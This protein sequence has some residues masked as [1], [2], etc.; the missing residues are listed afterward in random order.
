[1]QT[2]YIGAG[3]VGSCS[4]AVMA[5]FGHN[6]V[7]Y[8]V[9][10]ERIGVFNTFNRDLIEASFFEQ[11]LSSLIIQNKQRMVFLDDYSQFSNYFDSADV[12]FICVPTPLKDDDVGDYDLSYFEAALSELS[13]ALTKRNGGAQEK[14][15]VV[16]VKSTVP[17]E[18]QERVARDFEKAGVKNF[19]VV[20]NPE[21]LVEGQAIKD[22][23]S[24][25]R[26]VVGASQEKDFSVMRELYQRF[27]N[28]PGV[29]YIEVNPREAAAGKLLSNYVLLS[30]LVTT[31]NVIGRTSEVIPGIQF[32]KLR[33][34]ITT[35]K[36]IGSYGF[37]NNIYA[38]GSCLTKDSS[39]LAHQIESAS[40]NTDQIRNILGGNLFHF[41]NFVERISKDAKFSIKGKT[42]AVFGLSFKRDTNDIRNSGAADMVARLIEGGAAQLRVYDPVANEMF[43]RHFG[44]KYGDKVYYCE[45]EQEALQGSAGCL[46]LTDWPQFSTLDQLILKVCPAPYLVVDGRRMISQS[47]NKL[48]DAGYD[49]VAV[50][51][52]FLKGKS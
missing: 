5:K 26:V 36:R 46:I 3:Y 27:Y 11:D 14:Y 49:V 13:A 25:D 42:L 28:A 40:G 9:N 22:S 17:I 2:L 4:A 19:G 20:S 30:R 50:G 6:A 52:P 44:D 47:Y 1:M 33:K 7:V 34:I 45:S 23:F 10:K 8:D 32:E 18:T 37:Y 35:D 21:F 38:G 51:S 31:F 16:A 39:A 41:D 15:V 48:Q 12:I 29:G 24:P 43:K